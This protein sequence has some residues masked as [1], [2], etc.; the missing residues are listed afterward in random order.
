MAGL[1]GGP[2]GYA[3]LRRM[4]RAAAAGEG[5]CAGTAYMG[6]SKLDVVLG[7]EIWPFLKGKTVVDFGCGTGDEAI[8]MARR[9]AERV[10]G[11]DIREDLLTIARAAAEAAGVGERCAFQT[12]ISEP[13]DVI[14]SV[15]GFEHYADPAAVLTAMRS[16]I[17]QDGRVLVAF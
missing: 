11:L 2:L 5:P 3:L 12:E 17:H 7:R 14:V 15:D 10:I 8:E 13:A 1:I 6:R 16:L 4:G 9:G